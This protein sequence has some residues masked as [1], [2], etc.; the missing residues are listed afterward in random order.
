MRCSSQFP[1]HSF[2]ARKV[3]SSGI[4]TSIINKSTP[5]SGILR[6]LGHLTLSLSLLD[7][8]GLIRFNGLLILVLFILL[9]QHWTAH[10]DVINK[11]CWLQSRF[12]AKR[13][14]ILVFVVE[15]VA[16]DKI[17]SVCSNLLQ[18]CLTNVGR[19]FKEE[20][21]LSRITS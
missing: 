9:L 17:E 7:S 6:C 5:N 4:I 15:K 1:R 14:S 10:L 12:L 21:I 19:E 3:I 18:K 13:A 20:G 8:L 2:Q 11:R 16:G